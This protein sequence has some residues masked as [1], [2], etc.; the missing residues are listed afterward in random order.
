MAWIKTDSLASY[1]GIVTLG[2]AWRMYGSSNG[3][4]RFQHADT[5]PAQNTVIGSTGLMNAKRET[6]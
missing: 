3:N 5:V 2:Y 6:L 1:D 4:I